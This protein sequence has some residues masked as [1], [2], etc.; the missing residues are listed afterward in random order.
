MSSPNEDEKVASEGATHLPPREL[1]RQVL[2]SHM[3]EIPEGRELVRA[4]WEAVHMRFP[5]V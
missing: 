3:M 2:A 1:L 4:A 5:H